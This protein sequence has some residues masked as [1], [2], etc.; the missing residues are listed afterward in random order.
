MHPIERLRSVARA[1]GEGPSVLVREAAEGLAGLGSDAM[2][3]VTA[4][5]RLVDRHPT[6]APLWWL[7]ARVLS[8]PEARAEAHR[9]AE[10]VRTDRTPQVLAECLPQDATVVVLGWPEQVTAALRR[11]ED[12][13]VLVVDCGGEGRGLA[14]RLATMGGEAV[15]VPDPSLG[16][17]VAGADLV[18][19]EAAALGPD[20]LVAAAGSRAAAAVARHAGVAVWAAVGVGRVLPA[21]LW[22]AVLAG[23]ARHGDE[24]GE[25]RE[26]VVPIDLVD[27]V[28]RPDGLQPAAHTSARSDC[29]AIPELLRPFG[30]S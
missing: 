19:L 12:L 23:M 4:C 18:V 6:V 11:R 25:A 15:V 10:A 1:Q 5:R 9:A 30:P 28:A 14:R 27:Q 20:G 21:R 29:P 7:A 16:T 3:T 24:R 17:A 8:S 13:E 22:K 26:E 2:G